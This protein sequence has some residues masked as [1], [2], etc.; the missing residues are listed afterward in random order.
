MLA[1]LQMLKLADEVAIAVANPERVVALVLRPYQ[2][3]DWQVARCFFP[4]GEN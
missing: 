3:L 1:L 4:Y 2:M